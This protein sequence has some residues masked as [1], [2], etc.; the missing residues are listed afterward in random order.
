MTYFDGFVAAVPQENRQAYID[1]VR[2]VMPILKQNGATR[3]VE[4]WGDEV[5]QGKVTD[6][7]RAAHKK[8][9]EVIVFSWIEWP[10]KD[11][12][13]AGM[14]AMMEDER[15]QAM[16]MP[17]D[18]QRMIYGGFSPILDEGAADKTAYVD[19]F[20]VPVP[21]ANRDAYK[22]MAAK[23][24]AVFAEYGAERVVE[25]WGDDVPDGKVTDFRR[26]VE[27][28]DGETIVF[29]WIEWPSKQAHDEAWPKMMADPRMK[30]DPDNMPF[31]GKRM[32]YGGFTTILAQ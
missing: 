5:P 7:H 26:A 16:K 22:A 11:A 29:S 1:H 3:L 17:F 32:I 31:D 28:K 24:A 8:D 4:N 30:P 19:G 9:G 6:F 14:K 2:E 13:D 12:R 18:G 27:A 23:A 21:T 25:A 20:V 10:S 15:M